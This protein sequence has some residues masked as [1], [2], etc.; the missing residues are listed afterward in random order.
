MRS[1]PLTDWTLIS[2][3]E[4]QAITEA[5]AAHD[6][7]RAAGLKPA[8]ASGAERILAV[9]IGLGS[10]DIAVVRELRER[11][12]AMGTGRSSDLSRQ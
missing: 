5:I 2:V 4:R 3:R 7:D 1:L 11:A 12:V 10:P 6:A 9:A 8:R